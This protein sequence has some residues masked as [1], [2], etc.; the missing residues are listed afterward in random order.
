M[1]KVIETI[2][3]A[4]AI[5]GSFL[6]ALKF[7]NVGYPFFLISSV[8]LLF[9]AIRQGQKNFMAMQGVFLTANLIGAFNYI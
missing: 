9:S 6:V 4:G 7:G 3:T 5:I 1:I 2:G 8:C